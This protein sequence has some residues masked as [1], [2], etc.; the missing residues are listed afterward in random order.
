MK[1]EVKDRIMTIQDQLGKLIDAIEHQT[2]N[3][4]EVESMIAPI[5]WDTILL[6]REIDE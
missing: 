5:L 6:W 1:Q 3:M 2:F 4:V